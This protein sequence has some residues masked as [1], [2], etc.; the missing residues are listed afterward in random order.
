MTNRPRVTIDNRRTVLVSH[1]GDGGGPE[2]LNRLDGLFGPSGLSVCRAMAGPATIQRVEQGGLAG[3]I[4][5]EDEPRTDALTLLRIIRS[6]DVVLPCWLVTRQAT[7]RTLEAALAL[8]VAGVMTPPVDLI[9]F[10]ETLLRHLG[11]PNRRN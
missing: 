9:G 6:I 2:W 4:V 11:D 3:A 7:R 10:S 5:I 8:S 1:G